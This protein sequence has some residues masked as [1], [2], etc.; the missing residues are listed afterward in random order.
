MHRDGR[1]V[2]AVTAT[3]DRTAI[4]AF[5][6][7]VAFLATAGLAALASAPGAVF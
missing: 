6:W 5:G 4:A 7:Y 3:D 2:V 1:K